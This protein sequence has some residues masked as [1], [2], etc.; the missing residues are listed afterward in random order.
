MAKVS[1]QNCWEHL[2][3]PE[4]RKVQ[5]PAFTKQRGG[6][7]WKVERTLCRG[8]LQ[9]TMTQKIVSCRK[10]DYYLNKNSMGMGLRTKLLLS[11]ASILILLAV[12]SGITVFQTKSMNT[13]YDTLIEGRGQVAL[14]AKEVTILFQENAIALRTYLLTGQSDY[15]DRYIGSL[16]RLEKA[17]KD[18]GNMIQTE[19]G[20][21]R[22]EQFYNK[23]QEFTKYADGAIK[24]KEDSIKYSSVDFTQEINTYMD[25]NKGIVRQVTAAGNHLSSYAAEFMTTGHKDNKS[26]GASV[27]GT[28]II[29]TLIAMLMGL[30][31][32]LYIAK[33]IANPV[34][35]LEANA[36]RVAEGDLTVD[37]VNIKNRDEIGLLAVAFNQMVESLRDIAF[38]LKEKSHQVAV[39]AQE[40]TSNSEQMTEVTMENGSTVSELAATVDNVAADAQNVAA[41]SDSAVKLAE[42]GTRAVEKVTSQMQVIS[43]STQ[44]VSLRINSLGQKSNEISQIVELITQIADQTNLLALNA[45]IEAARA[46]EAG[47]G[48]AVVAEEVRKLAE[49]SA[50]AAKDIKELINSIQLESNEAVQAISSGVREVDEGNA[51]VTNVGISFKS[52]IGTIN[53]LTEQV[54]AV[55]AASQEMAAGIQNVSG[56][57]EEQTASM[58]E[59][60]AAAE[61]L[62]RMSADLD[63]LAARFKV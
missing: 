25:S 5:C 61:S 4:E 53:Q 59:V 35:A 46:G 12:V 55:A 14:T 56:T 16:S 40:L 24:L 2:K 44:T 54:H 36:S 22:F 1:N 48:F 7:C 27:V 9:G 38:Q 41:A 6:D 19:E 37:E 26:K 17:F 31:I 58:E 62:S 21:R 23:Y 11:F 20:K 45:A 29:I 3:C 33:I 49:Q 60:S 52:I 34:R 13:S 47:R 18:L 42:E 8:E 39:A 50:S 30:A 57:M 43:N 63:E 15:A 10:C 32:A 28:S 51:V